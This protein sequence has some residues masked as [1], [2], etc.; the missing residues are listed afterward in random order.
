MSHVA[1]GEVQ[2]DRIRLQCLRSVFPAGMND[3][4]A[5]QR[6][7]ERCIEDAIVGKGV[8]RAVVAEL[9][10]EGGDKDIPIR[11]Q[12]AAGMVGHQQRATG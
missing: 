11:R 10:V 7:A 1:A 3:A 6:C 2:H 9:A 4:E 8:Q 12:H 5:A